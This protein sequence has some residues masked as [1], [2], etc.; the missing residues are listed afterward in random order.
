MATNH[1]AVAA[2]PISG[3]PNK[4][5]LRN[6]TVSRMPYVLA[7]ADI[8][9]DLVAVDPST[10]ATIIDILYLGR[11]F[12][13]DSTDTT[14]ANDGITCLVTFEGRRYKLSDAS[15][16]FAYSVLNNTIA[17]P[18][19]SPTIG[20]AYLIA[21]G[22]TGAWSGK[23]NYIG[24]YTRRG[25]EFINFDI[26]R[27]VYVESVDT[28]YHKNSGGSWVSGF[29]NQTFGSNSVPLSAAINFGKRLIVENQTT[30]A[31]PGS[32]TIGVAYIIG[33]SPT[34]SW[35]GQ[36]TKIAICENGSTFTIYTPTN[37]WSAYDK[38][39]NNTY[40]FT[41][42]AWI[43]SAG[44]IVAYSLAI[45]DTS[46]SS[47]TGATLYTISNTAP[48]T[49]NI[50]FN[51]SNISYT[52]KKTGAILKFT[53]RAE[54]GSWNGLLA[55]TGSDIFPT[56]ALF[57]D[58]EVNAIDWHT[59]AMPINGATF[60]THTE[61]VFYITT[62]DATSH[63]YY[64]AMTALRISNNYTFPATMFRRRL[65]IEEFA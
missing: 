36:A 24:T 35:A 18:P 23:S 49:T 27:F 44:A 57:R 53:Y 40:T 1:A 3:S 65:L 59:V 42:S 28:Y 63:N 46:R 38:A 41:G 9:T 52:P 30:N 2:L 45:N 62:A 50:Q 33:P 8:A 58:S 21:A 14:T 55:S 19:A 37:G 17:T 7:D 61:G 43:S 10:A 16:V 6:L 32:P 51:D 5:L 29:G 60:P 15:D 20:D 64:V 13:Y 48:L 11:V 34:G 47:T 39:Q 4:T 54:I 25:W 22:A 12:H 56:L 31:P 26:G